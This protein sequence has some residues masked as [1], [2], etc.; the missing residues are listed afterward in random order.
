MLELRLLGG[1]VLRT[2][3]GPVTGPASYRHPVA[4]LA[5]LAA[6][7]SYTLSRAKLIG[8]LWPDVSESKGRNRLTSCLYH[9]RQAAGPGTLTSVGGALRLEPTAV[10][11]DVWEFD[12]A[13]ERGDDAAAADLYAGPFLDGFYLDGAS[14]FEQRMEKERHRLDR[15]YRS[16]LQRLTEQAA[17]SGDAIKASHWWQERAIADPY[18]STVA[19]GLVR[20]LV[21]AGRRIEALKAADRHVEVLRQEFDAEP[22][23]EF[24]ALVRQLRSDIKVIG[25][26]AATAGSSL[27]RFTGPSIAVLPLEQLNDESD[28]SFGE[29]IHRGLLT[30]LA[31][32]EG[33][34]VIARTSVDQFRSQSRPASEIADELDVEWVLEGDVQQSGELFK[35]NVRLIDAARD[36]QV[37]GREYVG[38]LNSDEVFDLQS[39]ITHEIISRLQIVLTPERREHVD[40]SP[41]RDLEAYRLCM[42]GRMYL[43]RRSREDMERALRCFEQ[44]T[45]RDPDYALAWVGITDSLGLLHAYGHADHEDVLPRAEAALWKALEADPHSGEAHAALGRLLGQRGEQLAALRT[46]QRAIELKPSYAEA[47]NWLCVGSQLMGRVREALEYSRRAVQLNPLSPEVLYNLGMSYLINGE[48]E[49]ALAEARRGLELAPHYESA[50]FLEGIILY[51]MGRFEDALRALENLSVPWAGSG[52]RTVSLLAHVAMGNDGAA[53]ESL[54][55]ISDAGHL[56]DIGI[57][58]VALGDIGPAFDALESVRVDGPNFWESYWP[59]VGV[60]YLFAPVWDGVREDPRYV[61]LRSRLDDPASFRPGQPPDR[62]DPERRTHGEDGE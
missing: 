38:V 49:R 32:I 55:L 5:S 11:C 7:S 60:R 9:V 25:D 56:F 28:A 47:H 45:E 58:R 31:D 27:P 22:A 51:E 3:S 46:I 29:G 23:E 61:N 4:L 42:Q 1:A 53:R 10:R 12:E 21:A 30:R 17:G 57:A 54:E 35:L 2:E 59:T 37:W 48:H 43:D 15:A 39:D 34:G 62:S 41:T 19:S 20:S 52:P 6:S 24:L 14:L 36:R 26:R 8:L 44:A 13:I 50:P 40:R 16:A 33:L 18:D